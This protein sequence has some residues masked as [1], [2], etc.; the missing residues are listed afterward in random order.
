MLTFK[1]V[2]ECLSSP[3]QNEALC[4][5]GRNQ[6]TCECLPGYQGI[7]CETGTVFIYLFVCLF[8]CL[9]VC[10]YVCLLVCFPCVSGRNQFTCA[11]LPG[12][13]SRNLGVTLEYTL[14]PNRNS[15]VGREQGLF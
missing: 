10:L 8:V 7:I 4:I 12:Y 15:V 6:F 2:D 5:N 9:C 1:D 13:I 14:H 11:C 3:C